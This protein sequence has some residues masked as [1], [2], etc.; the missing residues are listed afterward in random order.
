MTFSVLTLNF[1]NVNPPLDARYAALEAG[2]KRLRPDIVCLQEINR[3]PKSG[4][5]QSELIARMCGHTHVVEDKGLAIVCSFPVVRS[6]SAPLPEFPGDF[7]RRLLSA[8]LLIESRPLL[9]SDTHLAYPPKMIQERRRQA[10]TLLGALKDYRSGG[11]RGGGATIL[12]GDFND[13]AD[14][15]AIRAVLD[16]DEGY[17]DAFATCHPSSPG[18]TYACHNQYVEPSWT[19]DERID[20]IFASGNLVPKT[21]SVVFDGNKGFD[22]VSDHFGVFC[23]LAFRR[24]KLMG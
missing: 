13:V 16:S 6:H 7:P 15:P 18:F 11:G 24:A 22:F 12:C 1:W 2:L 8:E 10:E 9:V 20:Y 14:S 19:I 3:D 21:C 17:H 23:R 5:N 4:Q